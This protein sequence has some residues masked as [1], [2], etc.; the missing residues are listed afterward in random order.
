MRRLVLTLLFLLPFCA[1]QA[2]EEH[3]V[4]AALYLS[5]ASSEEEIPADWIERLEDA[6][7]VR[8]NSPY[9]R[10]GVI[11]TDYQVACILDYRARSGDILS[12]DEL[13]L[14][15]GFSREAVEAIRP[16]LSLASDRL[17]GQADTTSRVRASAIVRTTLSTVGAKAKAGGEHWRAGG[18]W[19]GRSWSAYAEGQWGRSRVLAG[20]FQARWGQGVGIWTGFSMES[21][22]TVDAFVKRSTGLSPVWSYAPSNVLRGVSYEYCGRHIRAAA[23]AALNEAFGGHADYL[24]RNG[25]V[26]VTVLLDKGN[27]SASLDSRYNWKGVDYVGEIGYKNRSVAGKAAVR[28]KWSEDWKW[29]AQA[30]VIPSQF[31]GK[32][33]GEYALAFGASFMQRNHHQLSF[34]ADASLLPISGTDPRRF[35]LRVYGVWQWNLTSAW[36]LDLRFTERYRTYEAPRTD[37][38]L[39]VKANFSPWLSIL[40]VEADYCDAWG[41]LGYWEGGYKA[42]KWASYLRVT[43]F[44]INQWSARIYCYER[45]A[46]GT[47]SVPAYNG[48]GVALSL[49]GSLKWRIGRSFTL[50]AHL[51]AACQFRAG[52]APAPTLNF[53]LQGDI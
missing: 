2:Q 5:G 39:D 47:F 28:G 51:R 8:I 19:R 3:I 9:L 4:K 10:P 23:Y 24:W 53:Q 48:R 29:A 36:L 18:A 52:S 17:P 22:S 33:Y 45:D 11:L 34:T 31:S 44:W 35:Q 41:F 32:K 6:R 27:F 13:A 30:R 20:D 42:E 46:P 15:D 40:R 16:F 26:G 7:T 25:Q 1:L 43:G 37:V 49:V 14:V 21:L 12:L 50:K 38:R